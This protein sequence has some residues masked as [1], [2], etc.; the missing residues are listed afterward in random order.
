MTVAE[1]AATSG[2]ED[3]RPPRRDR[4]PRWDPPLMLRHR[5]HQS[6]TAPCPAVAGSSHDDSSQRAHSRFLGA[7]A[8]RFSPFFDDE[9]E[10]FPTHDAR[11]RRKQE[12]YVT[13]IE[14]IIVPVSHNSV[15]PYSF[16][17]ST[18]VQVGTS[19]SGVPSQRRS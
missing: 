12:S 10:S 13:L 15:V 2:G 8:Q 16:S 4:S 18:G 19:V 6:A 1:H 14:N 9:L 5:L 3:V 11:F 17:P 7:R